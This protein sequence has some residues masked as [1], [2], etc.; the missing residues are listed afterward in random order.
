MKEAI[1]RKAREAVADTERFFADN[2][3]GIEACARSLASA[4]DKGARL[5]AFGNGGSACDAEHVAVEFQHPVVEKRR[6]L[7]AMAL[8]TSSALMTAIANDKDFSQ[9]YA[10][11]LVCSRVP[12]TSRWGFRQ[13]VG[14]A[15]SSR[16]SRRRAVST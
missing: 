6:A 12:G 1:V 4:F 8:G 14:R 2:A 10:D 11:P 15:A 3:A 5:Y 13:A 16:P 9:A 7:P